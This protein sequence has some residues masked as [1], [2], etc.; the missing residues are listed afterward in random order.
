MAAGLVV[1]MA[2]VMGACGEADQ[3]S[4]ATTSTSTATTSTSTSTS[5]STTR[6]SCETVAFTPQSE[7]AASQ[8][9]ATGLSC[10]EAEAFVR[11]AGARTSS[12]GPSSVRVDGYRCVLTESRDDPLPQASYE[13][14]N[15]SK[16]VTFVRS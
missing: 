15:D 16:V 13:C 5:S 2:V 4:S 8:V 12:G 10:E 14:R 1:A 11:V 9:T 3:P 6:Q 7:D